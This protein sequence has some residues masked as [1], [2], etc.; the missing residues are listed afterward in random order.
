MAA[1]LAE[2]IAQKR[3]LDKKIK[4]V[5]EILQHEQSDKL[6]QELFALLELRQSKLLNI[7][8]A[9]HA[10]KIN[11]GGTEVSIA[12]AIQ[13]RNTIKEKIDVI[14]SLIGNQA[15]ELDK[16]ELQQQRDRY[17]DE[18]VLLTMGITRNDLKVTIS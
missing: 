14:T 12:V 7:E 11:I 16:I 17:Y 1:Y 2:I 3:I 13:L 15:C 4:E 10:S 9:N 18:Y 8:A 6:S 5:K